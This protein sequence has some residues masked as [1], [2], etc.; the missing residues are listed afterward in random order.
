MSKA[1]AVLMAVLLIA[2]LSLSIG[3]SL[4]RGETGAASFISSAYADCVE[5]SIPDITDNY[6]DFIKSS[7]GLIS[8]VYYNKCGANELHIFRSIGGD[9]LVALNVDKAMTHYAVNVASIKNPV[10]L[11]GVR[12]ELNDYKSPQ[13]ELD[14]IVFYYNGIF[15]DRFLDYAKT[16]SEGDRER[17]R[18][19][20]EKMRAKFIAKGYLKAE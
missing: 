4:R 13:A 1:S 7:K 16:Q 8:V 14:G 20:G 6:K 15:V 2:L 11:K 12:K 3:G 18:K 17:V 5:L 10:V 9:F 19:A